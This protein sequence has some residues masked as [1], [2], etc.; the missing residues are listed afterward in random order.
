MAAALVP[1]ETYR[2]VDDPKRGSRQMSVTANAAEY[3]DDDWF[4]L[5]NSWGVALHPTLYIKHGEALRVSP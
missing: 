3:N 1:D 4:G 2:C 5:R